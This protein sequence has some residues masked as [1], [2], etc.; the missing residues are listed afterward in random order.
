MQN[1]RRF[2]IVGGGAW[3]TALATVLLR[4]GQDVLLWSRNPGVV[5]DIN[6]S[7]MNRLFLPDIALSPAL[8][9]TEELCEME[10]CD[11]VFLAV[12]AQ[13]LREVSEQ[14]ASY[15]RPGVPLVICAKGIERL[16]GFFMSQILSETCPYSCVA[17]LSGPG[18]ACD[19]CRGHPT[20]VTVACADVLVG[21]TLCRALN[22]VSFRPYFSHDV[23]GAQIGGAVKNVLAIACGVSEGRDFGAS[24]RAALTTR[25]FVEL[26]RFGLAFGANRA[27]LTGLSGLGDV[28]LTCNAMQSRNM[29]LGV[30]IGTGGN[31]D[32][33][34]NEKGAVREGVHTV[35]AVIRLADERGISMPISQAVYD[36]IKGR[37]SVDEVIDILLSRPL[38]VENEEV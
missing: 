2:G 8:R 1:M 16:T 34:L 38:K 6:E 26:F 21:H 4:A 30:A 27:T 11:A 10:T 3:G 5:S 31:V 36:L 22:S 28:I 12:P 20:A 17:V 32:D 33:I 9:A 14:C 15:L 23:K 25:G 7:H 37:Y 13:S 29:S 35:E 24:A 18:F 19:V